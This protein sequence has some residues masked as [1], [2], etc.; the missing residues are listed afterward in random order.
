[1]FFLCVSH[2][3]FA[4][5][6]WGT[7]QIIHEGTIEVKRTRTSTFTHEYG[8]FRIK[9]EENIQDIKKQFTHIVNHM[10]TLS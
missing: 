3:N 1:M 7:L 5:E 2:Y 8:L 9:P 10:R 4:K 6:T